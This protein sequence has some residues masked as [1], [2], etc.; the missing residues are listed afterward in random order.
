[1]S[2]EPK[3]PPSSADAGAAIAAETTTFGTPEVV[4]QTGSHDDTEQD[5]AKTDESQEFRPDRFGIVKLR[6]TFLSRLQR[7]GLPR[8][9]T[10]EFDEL[11][12]RLEDIGQKATSDEGQGEAPSEP[13]PAP[14]VSRGRSEKRWLAFLIASGLVASLSGI[15]WLLR[16]GA[17][18]EAPEHPE[19]PPAT[20]TTQVREKPP[21]A[22]K[23][24]AVDEPPSPV[25]PESNPNP[26]PAARRDATSA[27][28]GAK[29]ARPKH[30]APRPP[31]PATNPSTPGPRETSLWDQRLTAPKD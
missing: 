28:S 14:L 20:A 11:A 17:S 1:M 27:P 24:V 16:P 22:E 10:G 29:T 21:H 19:A 31:D 23:D 9:P 4:R 13:P 8:V 26:S 7:K 30:S 12:K 5:G 2:T 25:P 6:D 3:S 15:L 18:K